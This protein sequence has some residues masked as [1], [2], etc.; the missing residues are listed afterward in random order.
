MY[1]VKKHIFLKLYFL[2]SSSLAIYIIIAEEITPSIYVK[3]EV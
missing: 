2:H 1:K 3:K